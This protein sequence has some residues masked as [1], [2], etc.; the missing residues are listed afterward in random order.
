MILTTIL[1]ILITSII[2]CC[3]LNYI[4]KINYI[5]SFLPTATAGINKLRR[6]LESSIELDIITKR[7][8]RNRNNVKQ[9]IVI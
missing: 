7:M 8:L 1:R 2:F 5:T 9:D 4:K 3:K 6:S